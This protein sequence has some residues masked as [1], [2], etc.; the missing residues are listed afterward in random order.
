[1][2]KRYR[3]WT[4]V[5]AV[6]T[7]FCMLITVLGAFFAV[8]D[9]VCER[10]A[11][12]LPS[13]EKIDLSPLIAKA[14]WTDEDYETIY[15]QTGLTKA[16]ADSVSRS[17]LPLFQESFF[18]EGEVYHAYTTPITPHDKL[19][20]PQ[21]G[22]DFTAPIVPLEAGDILVSSSTHLF[23]WRHGH[24]ALVTNG[25]SGSLLQSIAIG[26]DSRISVGGTAWFQKSSNF[27]V[28][29][30]KDA[31]AATRAKIASDA[32]N[33]LTG[34][35]YNVFVGFFLPKDQCK[36]GRT[37]T[38]TH[39]A[40][41][42]WQS[43]LNAGYDLDPTGGPLVTPDDIAASPLLEVVQVYGFDPDKLWT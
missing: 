11:R 42:V 3:A 41:L 16:G 4:I 30:L 34:L 43:F 40:H 14:E 2:E 1:M 28:L 9:G 31:D 27:M 7:C 15:R 12:I 6:F 8:A 18:F 36:D 25:P 38:S 19:R 21:T 29:R 5:L 23:G 33:A 17:R 39:C 37:P 35:S 13:Y 10:S 24:A 32:E 26:V 20:D 22:K